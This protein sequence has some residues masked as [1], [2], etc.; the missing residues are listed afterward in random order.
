MKPADYALARAG[1]V[2]LYKALRETQFRE[3]ILVIYL[4]EEA[5]IVGESLRDDDLDLIDRR[6]LD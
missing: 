1:L 4:H 2:E 3:E 5:A 6:W